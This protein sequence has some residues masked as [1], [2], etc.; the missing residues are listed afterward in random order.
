MKT[1]IKKALDS[2]VSNLLTNK[3]W[4][5]IALKR[6]DVEILAGF[7]NEEATAERITN[8]QKTVKSFSDPR[9]EPNQYYT[10]YNRYVES[11]DFVLSFDYRVN[12]CLDHEWYFIGDRK[13]G[14]KRICRVYLVDDY[15]ELAVYNLPLR[16]IDECNEIYQFANDV[17]QAF[18]IEPHLSE[19]FYD[20][21]VKFFGNDK[22]ILYDVE[23]LAEYERVD[24]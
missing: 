7:N 2:A 24:V 16:D 14:I 19:V 23:Y 3:S 11:G 9:M 17:L 20:F 8:V 10:V 18:T 6:S 15:E 4:L 5:T 12:G 21:Q 1:K 22:D 13:N